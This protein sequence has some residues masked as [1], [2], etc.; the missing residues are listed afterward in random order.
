MLIFGDYK[1]FPQCDEMT[2]LNSNGGF[3]V[4][5]FSSFVQNCSQLTNLLPRGG[6]DCSSEENFD[7]SYFD[8][9]YNDDAAFIDLMYIID[10]LYKGI[11]VFV[12]IEH[13]DFYDR[14]AESLAEIIKQRY[15]YVSFFINEYSDYENLFN[16]SDI[17]DFSI[18]GLNNLD[19]DR[20]RFISLLQS[21]GMVKDDPEDYM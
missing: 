7:M 14:L 15:G 5:N 18:L 9:I 17:G 19:N 4:F 6:V 13:T 8:Y 16:N 1:C 20:V 2:M 21:V 12:I 3:I 11:N 10:Q